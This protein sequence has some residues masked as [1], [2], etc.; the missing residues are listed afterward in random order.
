MDVP[1]KQD[2]R[3]RERAYGLWEAEGRPD[4]CAERHWKEAEFELARDSGQDNGKASN[5]ATA[6]LETATESEAARAPGRS[7]RRK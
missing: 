5:A 6:D 2:E 1:P 3:I 4:G 7:R